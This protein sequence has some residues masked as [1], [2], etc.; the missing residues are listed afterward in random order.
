[1]RDNGPVTNREIELVDGELI[2]SRT[3]TAGRI[4]FVN[5]AFMTISGFTEPELIGQPHNI[6]RHP[7]MPKQAF[8]DLWAT[9]KSGNPWEGMVKNR[10]KNGDHYWV[11]ANVTPFIE[12]GEVAGYI[13]IRSKASRAD[14][15]EA[16][17][18][19]ARLRRGE[20]GETLSEGRVE[21]TGALAKVR[22]WFDSVAG[23][24]MLVFGVM[25]M[26]QL[27]IGA[28]GDHAASDDNQR[29][30][31]L[32]QEAVV[33]LRRLKIVSD[34]YA[35]FI[36]DASHKVRNGNFTW[37]QGIQSITKARQDI[38]R[39]WNAF[40]SAAFDADEKESVAKV[41]QLAGPANQTV[42][43]LL[44][45]MR[46]QD[47]AQLDDLVKNHL[48]QTID[49]VTDVISA[50][51]DI[52]IA[53]GP[54]FIAESEAE[55]RI[56]LWVNAVVGLMALLIT[57]FSGWWLSRTLNQP[58]LSMRKAFE[59]IAGQQF[60][61]R[62]DTTRIR[63]F[64]GLFGQLRAT[65]AKLAFSGEERLVNDAKAKAETRY[66]LLETIQTVEA[67]LLATWQGVEQ[68]SQRVVAGVGRL[69]SAMG[70]V[71]N[72]ASSLSAVAEQSSANA[73]NV[74]AATEEL[75]ASGDEIA[76]QAALSS[77]VVVRA[78]SSARDAERAV[79]RM[80]EA[81]TEIQQVVG[82]IAE[83]AA[84]TN[85]LALNA[86]IEAARAGEAGKGFAVVAGEVKSLSTQTRNA[87]DDIAKRI[88]AVH[89]AVDGS[90]EGIRAVIRVVEEINSAAAATADAVT[91]QSAAS[92][93][94]GRNADQ[95]AAGSAQV[96]SSVIRISQEI[97]DASNVAQE[98]EAGIRDSHQA[99][100]ALRSR[101]ITTLRQSVAGD[102][103]S[104]DRI[105]T[106][107]PVRAA[108][109]GHTH[110]MRLEDLSE[111]GGLLA[112]LPGVEFTPA[113]LMQLDIPEIGTVGARVVGVTNMGIH[114]NFET[115][116]AM[117][118]KLRNY[119]R[120][121][122]DQEGRFVKAAQEGGER[123]GQLLANA[124]ASGRISEEALF[125]PDLKLVQGTDP[126]QYEAPYTG[127]TD[128]LFP[129]VQEALLAMDPNVQFCAAVNSAGYL[130]THNKK[131]SQP[132]RQGDRNWNLQHSRHRRLFDDNAGVAAARNSRPF[133]IQ[134]YMREMGDG[135]SVRLMEIDAPITVNGRRWGNLRL[136]Y[137]K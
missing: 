46:A 37:D 11:R 116:P 121:L 59:A 123:I 26:L 117:L 19:Y 118:E 120:K 73:Q 133:L 124:V 108:V 115:H 40:A 33:H 14:I 114:V 17:A 126:Q 44:A 15:A 31:E 80:A 129:E 72:N 25:L 75:G 64:Q 23:R 35:V 66:R 92:A 4:T 70:A 95:S 12:K 38:D 102:R 87:T 125:S 34:A 53:H 56:L 49:P 110:S 42:E 91:Q 45:A 62:I 5:N 131:Y 69:G 107:L 113:M 21:K 51:A 16:E 127:L 43:G 100:G 47:R 132:Y 67:D 10:C 134:T 93:E 60:D 8:A 54:S 135:Q 104:Q 63:E 7:D 84:Q 76:R 41:L 111:E 101:L 74:A 86:T 83:I 1:M 96:T 48:Y 98:V 89:Q 3:D 122:I 9:V 28:I 78:V 105:P 128:S 68:S 6:I 30:V 58:L 55:N 24:L 20:T 52:Q 29:L 112:L 61:Y 119:V 71:R 90:V 94:I 13:S 82:L 85:L 32:N 106:D 103:R 2:V 36:V 27:V 136:A 130:P 50:L 18:L 39:E 77:Q 97:D 99:F 65:S 79:E 81:A 88:A 22:R 57:L 109:A 137:R